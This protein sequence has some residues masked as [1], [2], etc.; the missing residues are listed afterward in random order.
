MDLSR[1]KYLNVI[2]KWTPITQ[3]K[4]WVIVL[5]VIL[6]SCGYILSKKVD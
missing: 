6:L 5:D 2:G 1:G 4:Y 3:L